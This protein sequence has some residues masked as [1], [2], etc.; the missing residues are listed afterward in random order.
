MTDRTKI[1]VDKIDKTMDEVED[2]TSKVQIRAAQHAAFMTMITTYQKTSEE[3]NQ[4]VRNIING[5]TRNM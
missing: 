3:G 5:A 1:D 4:V 2:M